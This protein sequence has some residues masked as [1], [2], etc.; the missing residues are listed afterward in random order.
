MVNYANITYNAPNPLRRFSHRKRFEKT[1][2]YVT[3]N[4][5]FRLLD[6]GCGDGLFLN[7][8]KKVTT[9][10]SFLIGFE[11]ILLPIESNTVNI[12]ANLEEVEKEPPFDYITCLEVLEHFDE[13]EQRKMLC[14]LF[15]LL[16]DDGFLIVSVPI[17]NGLPSLVKNILRRISWSKE[18]RKIFSVKNIIY[19]FFKRKILRTPS[20][21]GY[22]FLHLGFYHK[23]LEHL[24]LE[25]FIITKKSFSPF[26][27]FGS[28]LNAQVFYYL[29]KVKG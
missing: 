19:A 26:N 29:K 27:L 17:E 13:F 16:S 23:D 24:L 3:V 11:P 21:S 8:L 6:Y 20:E 14:K 28:Q 22:I 7:N 4:K 2:E 10:K 12:T 18:G 5:N 15:S 1:I 25:K 9:E